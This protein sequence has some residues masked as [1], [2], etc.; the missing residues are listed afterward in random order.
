M[1]CELNVHLGYGCLNLF[2]DSAE[3]RQPE[4]LPLSC[5]CT[6][7]PRT[8]LIPDFTAMAFSVKMAKFHKKMRL[9]EILLA[10]VVCYLPFFWKACRQYS[11]VDSCY[12]TLHFIKRP[13]RGAPTTCSNIVADRDFST[14]C[15]LFTVSNSCNLFYSKCVSTMPG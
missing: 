10:C 13:S 6:F 9:P 15:C 8:N 1:L 7:V 2:C 3:S 5:I 11:T 14:G 12:N 4:Q